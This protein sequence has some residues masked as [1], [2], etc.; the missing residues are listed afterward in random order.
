MR[1]MLCLPSFAAVRHAAFAPGI[2]VE[3][4]STKACC[5]A[6]LALLQGCLEAATVA[7][8]AADS[9]SKSMVQHVCGC[10]STCGLC[11]V[12]SCQ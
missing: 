6:R 2:G 11:R 10:T 12:L 4:C 9:A 7:N 1:T 5:I 8:S 3:L